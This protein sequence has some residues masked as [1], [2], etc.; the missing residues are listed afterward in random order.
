MMRMVVA[1]YL[2]I[3]SPALCCCALKTGLGHV[4]GTQM[5]CD[6]GGCCSKSSIA[7]APQPRA[8]PHCAPKTNES[9]CCSASA[10]RNNDESSCPSHQGGGCRCHEKSIDRLPLDTGG[11]IILPVLSL[12][13]QPMLMLPGDAIAMPASTAAQLLAQRAYPPPGHSLLA[14]H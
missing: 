3:W 1:M 13:L 8:C 14:Q 12:L 7:R 6:Q 5:R 10:P 11:K 2:A 4:T 9:S